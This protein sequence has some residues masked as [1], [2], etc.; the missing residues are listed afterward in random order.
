MSV[1][2]SILNEEVL[3]LEKNI[4]QYNKMV[5]SLPKGSIFIRKIGNSFFVYRKRRENGKV[6]SQYLGNKKSKEAQRQIELSHE[7]HRICSNIKVAEK[8]LKKLRKA[9]K[10]YD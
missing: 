4:A 2:Q 3:R 10:A 6:V 1:I 9:C 8:E 5:L 7:Y